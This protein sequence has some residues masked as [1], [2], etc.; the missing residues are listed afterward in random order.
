MDFGNIADTQEFQGNTVDVIFNK[1]RQPR[2]K[3]PVK[4]TEITLPLVNVKQNDT[5]SPD[6]NETATDS[7][8]DTF[9]FTNENIIQRNKQPSSAL[10]NK[11]FP[12]EVLEFSEQELAQI[13]AMYKSLQEKQLSSSSDCRLTQANVNRMDNSCLIE[14]FLKEDAANRPPPASKSSLDGSQSQTPQLFLVDSSE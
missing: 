2:K 7:Q 4:S 11:Y 8:E 1:K 10:F 13:N 12:P 5:E 14:R 3:K 6:W 9:Q